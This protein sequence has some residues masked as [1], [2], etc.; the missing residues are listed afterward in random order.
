MVDTARTLAALQALLAD[1]VTADIS[2]QDVRDF[3]ASVFPQTTKGDLP[4]IAAT[5]VIGRLGIG[6][7]DTMLVADSGQALGFKWAAIAVLVDGSRPLTGDWDN[8]GRRIRN[9]GVAEVAAAAPATPATGLLWLDTDATGT[10]GLGVLNVTTITSDDTLT[11][12]QTVVLCDASSGAITVTLPAASGNDGRH[13]HV[14]KIDSSGNAVTIDGNGSETIDGETTQVITMQYNSIN[15]VC[16]G[17][18]WYIL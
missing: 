16:D 5:G 8:I 12:S 10:G 14:K 18:A 6:A 2:P 13:Y 11:T 7:N 15:I 17:S 9:T 4:G 1:N 3:L